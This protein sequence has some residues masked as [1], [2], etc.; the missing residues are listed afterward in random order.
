MLI[1]VACAHL[2]ASRTQAYIN[3]VIFIIGLL[4]YVAGS[5]PS[6]HEGSTC[7]KLTRCEAHPGHDLQLPTAPTPPSLAN[8]PQQSTRPHKLQQVH[9][10][11]TVE[12]LDDA[13]IKRTTDSLTITSVSKAVCR[14]RGDICTFHMSSVSYVQ[15]GGCSVAISNH[16]QYRKS[17]SV[18]P[19]PCRLMSATTG[20]F[21]IIAFGLI[22]PVHSTL[23][24]IWS[25]NIEIYC[26][27]SLRFVHHIVV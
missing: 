10:H 11:C 16:R 27:S 5:R 20:Q 8:A 14:R 22:F 4:Y 21:K 19:R 25:S 6:L 12:F 1:R 24:S 17:R 13:T 26:R 23:Y 9:M 18:F 3:M 7:Y 2:K 15:H